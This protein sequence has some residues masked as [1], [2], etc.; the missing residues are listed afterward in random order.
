MDRRSLES[1]PL[2]GLSHR[3]NAKFGQGREGKFPDQI[4]IEMENIKM[5]NET[6][7]GWT[8]RETWGA[9]LWIDNDLHYAV[10]DA[11]KEALRDYYD[12]LTVGNG[13]GVAGCRGSVGDAIKDAFEDNISMLV[14]NEQ[15]YDVRNILSDIGSLWRVDWAEIADHQEMV[16]EFMENDFP[17]LVKPE[18]LED[19]SR[20]YEKDGTP[21][22][23][24]V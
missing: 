16:I 22:R 9:A 7:N 12:Y 10:E 23:V 2:N 5:E 20:R 6:Y 1:V 17:D 18:H 4:E 21:K 15:A 24:T 8:N 11:V 19:F 3:P 13:I 14:D